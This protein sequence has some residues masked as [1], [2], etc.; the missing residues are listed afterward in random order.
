M[1]KLGNKIEKI[2]SVDSENYKLKVKFKDGVTGE[3]DLSDIF[4]HPKGIAAE[5]IKGQFF[6]KCFL[7][8]G[9]LAWP[10]GLELCPDSLRMNLTIKKTRKAA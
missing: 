5:I 3:L 10:N 8:S 9:G 6:G 1:K 2:V 7:E 4:S